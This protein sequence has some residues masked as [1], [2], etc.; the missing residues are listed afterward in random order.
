VDQP[1]SDVLALVG[2]TVR[3]AGVD[4]QRLL[5]VVGRPQLLDQPDRVEDG[6]RPDVLEEAAERLIVEGV[7]AGKQALVR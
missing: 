1:R 6:V 7:D 5:G 2:Q 4:R 3:Q